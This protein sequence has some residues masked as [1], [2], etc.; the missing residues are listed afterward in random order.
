LKA[1]CSFFGAWGAATTGGKTFQ[2]RALDYVTD[3]KSFTDNPLV[4]VY[5]PSAENQ[6]AH[7]AVSWP[8]MT[9]VLTGFSAAHLGISEIGVSFPDD[10]FGQG[11]ANTPPEK[12]KGQPWMSVLKDVASKAHSLDEAVGII[13]GADRTCNLIIGVG[14]GNAPRPDGSGVGNAVGIEYSGYVAVPY[15]DTTLLP[16]ND[17]WH[18]EIADIVYNGMDWNCANYDIALHDQLALYRGQIDE[19]T[20]IGNIL[21]TVQTGNL[22]VAVADLTDLNWHISFARRTTADPS[23]PMNGYERQFTRL[24]MADLFALPAPTV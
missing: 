12:L 6:V 24:H 3:A 14:D 18:P 2:L 22:H 4:V 19:T 15:N 11:T 16:K 8:G 1:S 10:S 9:G 17:T 13:Q 21:P 5:H 20:V 7:A 23:E